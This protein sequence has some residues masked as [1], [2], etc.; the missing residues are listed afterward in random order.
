VYFIQLPLLHQTSACGD[1]LVYQESFVELW[2]W[3]KQGSAL[4]TVG[5]FPVKLLLPV[6][7]PLIWTEV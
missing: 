1:S 2:F 7:L 5:F 4:L 3:W 6:L